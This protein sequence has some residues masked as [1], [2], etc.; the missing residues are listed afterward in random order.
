MVAVNAI[1]YIAAFIMI[2]LGSGL[3]VSSTSL[4][5][6]RL[7]LSSFAF[8]FVFLGLLTSIPEFSVGLQAVAEHDAEIFVGNLIGGVAMIF[9][10]IIPLLAI[11]GGGIN[12]KRE[13][14]KY[15]L[16]LTLATVLVPSLLIIDRR[17]TNLEGLICILL[18]FMLLYMIER[19]H[20]ILDRHNSRMLDAKAYSYIDILKAIAGICIVFFASGMIVDKTIYFAAILNTP[21]YYISLFVVTLGTNLPELSLAIRS[22][23]SGKKD[24]A[25]GDYMGSAAANTFLFGL[26]TVM[27][28]GE[29]LTVNNFFLSFIFIACA[30]AI[31]YVV[32]VTDN[33][34]SRKNGL[35]LLGIYALFVVLEFFTR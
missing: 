11:F 34:I 7:R 8:S 30:L 29:V 24:L 27:H 18:Y 20:G 3:I 22:V 25:M 21:A 32:S 28:D 16:L 14:D 2:W 26:L 17:V 13:M 1:L 31:F 19:N 4:L 12:L 6:R 23:I 5:S 35:L 10:L 15:A 9:L 33:F